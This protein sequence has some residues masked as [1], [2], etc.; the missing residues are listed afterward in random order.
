MPL[1]TRPSNPSTDSDPI[2]N[3]ISNTKSIGAGTSG[4]PP[5]IRHRVPPIFMRPFCPLYFQLEGRVH[6]TLFR[7]GRDRSRPVRA[8]TRATG[9]LVPVSRDHL[10]TWNEWARSIAIGCALSTLSCGR[11]SGRYRP[12]SNSAAVSARLLD[13]LLPLKEHVRFHTSSIDHSC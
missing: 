8:H 10:A 9:T 13:L 11:S 7:T 12:V 1:S 3:N 6:T 2:T 5:V 4:R